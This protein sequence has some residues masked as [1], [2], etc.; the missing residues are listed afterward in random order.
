MIELFDNCANCIP[1]GSALK[2]LNVFQDAGIVVLGGD[3]LDAEGRYTY[4]NWYFEFNPMLD[5]LQ[6]CEES[7]NRAKQY[8]EAYKE[9]NGT[10]FSVV[11]VTRES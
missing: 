5:D 10:D 9:R 1:F 6:N 7:I 3:I 8:I 2:E 11:F 4:D